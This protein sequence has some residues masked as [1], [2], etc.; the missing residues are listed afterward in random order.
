M[1]ILSKGTTATFL[2]DKT[3]DIYSILSQ[4]IKLNLALSCEAWG[5]GV[6]G[7]WVGDLNEAGSFV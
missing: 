4:K 1:Y 2:V 7:G 3:D 6:W 5:G